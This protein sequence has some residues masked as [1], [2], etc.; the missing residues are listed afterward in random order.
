MSVVNLAN[1]SAVGWKLLQHNPF[2]DMNPRTYSIDSAPKFGFDE[3]H[4]RE[5]SLNCSIYYWM[6]EPGLTMQISQPHWNHAR[7]L[8]QCDVS[9]TIR[10]K[11][12]T[13]HSKLAQKLATRQNAKISPPSPKLA[14]FGGKTAQLATLDL[15]VSGGTLSLIHSLTHTRLGDRS[16]PVA[17]PRLWNSI[18]SNLRQSDLTLQQFRRSLK[19]HLFGWPAPSDFCLQC[20]IHTFLLTYLLTW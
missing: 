5:S 20:A 17:G 7:L 6:A 18:P 16:F 11:I 15:Y 19:T 3:I 12:H 13:R 10:P 2:L 4:L 9:A 1:M 8:H 14:Q